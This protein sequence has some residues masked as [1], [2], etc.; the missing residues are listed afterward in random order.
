M[1]NGKNMPKKNIHFKKNKNKIQNESSE[2]TQGENEGPQKTSM[3]RKS[4]EGESSPSKKM[5][6]HNLKFKERKL[7]R[8]QKKVSFDVVKLLKTYWEDLRR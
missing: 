1:T 7:I 3:K 2:N 8:K 4:E 5:K 6:L